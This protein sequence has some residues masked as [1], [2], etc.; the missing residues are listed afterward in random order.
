MTHGY[1][2]H[3]WFDYRDSRSTPALQ[4]GEPVQVAI[5][6]IVTLQSFPLSFKPPF[7]VPG[8]LDR[9]YPDLA[10][11]SQRKVGER[12]GL[13]RLLDFLDLTGT[14]ATWSVDA[15]SCRNIGPLL[16][17]LRR[18]GFSAVAS[19]LDAGSIH[20]GYG[21][22]AAEAEMVRQALAQIVEEQGLAVEG[23]HPPSGAHSPDTLDILARAGLD[24]LLDLNNDELPFRIRCASGSLLCVPWQHF[25]SD[26]HCL[27][28]CRQSTGQY[29]D[30]I[31]QSIRWLGVEA[32]NKG[33]RLLTLPVHPWIV[34]VPHRFREFERG[35]RRW[36]AMPGVRFVNIRG[37]K[38][39][40]VETS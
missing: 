4:W 13:E 12:E 23:W 6:L 2:D 3:A 34:G 24:T 20:A 17:R 1:A 10:N 18:P 14:A 19:G 35:L 7:P 26:L 16:T 15:Q 21:D 32:L 9:P 30:D 37:V 31:E 8:G 11:W 27:Q 36:A 5:H 28:V 29:V 38:A 40:S 25:A 39:A 33:P 22:P